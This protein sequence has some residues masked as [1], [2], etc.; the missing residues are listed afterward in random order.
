MLESK[1]VI[2]GDKRRVLEDEVR[3]YKNSENAKE[4]ADRIVQHDLRG[5]LLASASL[6]SLLLKNDTLTD[7]QRE[8]LVMIENAGKGMLEILDTNLILYRLEEGKYV[9]SP[10]KVDILDT[11]NSTILNLKQRGEISGNEIVIKNS[12]AIFFVEGD[13]HLLHRAF[14]NLLLNAIE[15]STQDAPIH[16]TIVKGDCCCIKIHNSGEVPISIRSDFF[17]K[18]VTHGKKQGTG[19]GTYSA[20]LMIEAQHGGISL[21]SSEPGLTTIIVSL[22]L[23][24]DPDI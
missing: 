10:E 2:G 7:T 11:L 15:A 9:F 13:R 4:I 22:P 1:L 18:F 8:I 24:N 3:S 5:A 14:S 20:K 17:K 23:A 16:I 12:N 19:L 21:D 6:P